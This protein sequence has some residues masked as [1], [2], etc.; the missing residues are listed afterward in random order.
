MTSRTRTSG[1]LAAPP[2][3]QPA[4]GAP[5][6]GDGLCPAARIRALPVGLERWRTLSQLPKGTR[7]SHPRARHHRPPRDRTPGQTAGPQALSLQEEVE[8]THDR[9]HN[10]SSIHQL[11]V[12]TL[13]DLHTGS[14]S[15]GGEHRRLGATRPPLAAGDPRRSSRRMPAARGR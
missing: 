12:E 4:A 3:V 7:L 5:D 13:E 11:G 1:S 15:G 8:M 10:G 2:C 6:G 9:Y 14:G